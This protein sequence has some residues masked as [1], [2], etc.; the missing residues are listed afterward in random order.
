MKRLLFGPQRCLRLPREGELWFNEAIAQ[1]FAFNR[2]TNQWYAVAPNA[3]LAD[4][5]ARLEGLIEDNDG[6]IEDLQEEQP[7][8]MAGLML[9][10]SGQATQDGRPIRSMLIRSPRTTA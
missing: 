4:E 2:D 3:D 7:R 1:L 5:I 9:L 10:E 6:D 8:R